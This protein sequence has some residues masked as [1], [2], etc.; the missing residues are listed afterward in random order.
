MPSLR[1]LARFAA[2]TIAV[3][4]AA[5]WLSA[6]IASLD[7]PLFDL[8]R[9]RIG[10]AILAFARKFALSPAATLRL[11]CMLAGLKLLLGAY[12]LLAIVVATC[13]RV[14]RRA[15]GDE[16]LELGLFVSALASIVA[17]SPLIGERLRV[18]IA[19]GELLLCVMASGLIAFAHSPVKQRQRPGFVRQGLSWGA[20]RIAAAY[21]KARL[22]A[23]TPQQ[24][25]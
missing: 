11:A 7:Q 17:V 24:G 22:I 19:L 8:G 1:S 21:V 3:L 20:T 4:L 23:V 12:F 15:C 25:V 2:Y 6:G 5:V 9:P 16:M 18:G 13:E 10:D 14:R